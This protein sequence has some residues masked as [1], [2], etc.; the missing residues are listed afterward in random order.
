MTEPTARMSRMTGKNFGPA[1]YRYNQWDADLDENQTIEDALNPRFWVDQAGT[2]M[3]H[4]KGNPKGRGDLIHLRKMDT[5]MYVKLL[6][7]EI[8][9][10]YVKVI[11][12][13]GAQ[14]KEPE[15]PESSPLTTKW[16]VGR[17]VHEVVRKIDGGV[18]STGHQTKQ[19]AIDWITEHTKQ[20]AA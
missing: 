9:P 8:G 7:T 4:D 12:V 18:L 19:G 10:G 3:G 20:M 11:V 5:G 6:V 1:T 16:N 15:M 2:L 17:R 14:P 13:E